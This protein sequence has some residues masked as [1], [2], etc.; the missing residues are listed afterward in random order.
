[1]DPGD[2]AAHLE[3]VECVIADRGGRFGGEAAVL[4]SCH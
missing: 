2:E 4:R 1:M 3:V